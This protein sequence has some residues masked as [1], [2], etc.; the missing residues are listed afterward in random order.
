M[1]E[2][3]QREDDQ[4][5]AQRETIEA[6]KK[7]AAEQQKR[8]ESSSIAN[9]Q[10]QLQL[11]QQQQQQLQQQMQAHTMRVHLFWTE[12]LRKIQDMDPE[13]VST[14]RHHALPLARIKKIMKT[15]EDVKMISA[16]APVLFA[17][18]CELF[19]RDLTKRSW[20]HAEENK[21]R[22]LQRNDIAAAIGKADEFD[23]L[24]DIVPR[25]EVKSTRLRSENNAITQNMQYL[26]LQ[27]HLQQ[28]QVQAA[29]KM[30]QVG[31]Q[32][33][34]LANSGASNLKFGSQIDG[35]Q[36]SLSNP[37]ALYQQ[38]LQQHMQLQAQQQQAQQQQQQQQKDS[39]TAAEKQHRLVL[40]QHQQF[41]VQ[42]RMMHA[43]LMQQSMLAQQQEQ[44]QQQQRSA[45]AA[46][47]HL[48]TNSRP[49]PRSTSAAELSSTIDV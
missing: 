47:T 18:A 37:L 11:Q 49:A 24:I 39:E 30:G 25:E 7:L 44:Q 46:G 33:S 31:V 26:L 42:Q 12:E 34:N 23:C 4:Q 41:L 38:Q 8:A 27:Q 32:D 35:R 3:Q 15:D 6:Q 28:Q 20:L 17:K 16:E 10:H 14:F 22:T 1:E 43:H 29:I 36:F 9:A 48:S 40:L 13:N 45:V 5:K 21:R 19:I 2:E